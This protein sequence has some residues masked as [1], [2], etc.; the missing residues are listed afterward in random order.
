M[1][2][3]NLKPNR[4]SR[5]T[6]TSSTSHLNPKRIPTNTNRISTLN[7]TNR[8]PQRSILNKHKRPTNQ[9]L[10]SSQQIHRITRQNNRRTIR[11]LPLKPKRN[12]RT[13]RRPH[14]SHNWSPLSKHSKSSRS[15]KPPTP[16]KEKSFKTPSK[17]RC[18][19]NVRSKQEG[20]SPNISSGKKSSISDTTHLQSTQLQIFYT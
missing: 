19:T 15:S 4:L 7:T 9:V 18:A 5:Q 2:L 10:T 1:P 3:H 11:I 12:I 14:R 20:R 17:P 8:I 13:T 6:I 16:D